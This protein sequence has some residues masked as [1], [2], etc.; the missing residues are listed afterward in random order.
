[1][2]FDAINSFAGVGLK[3]LDWYAYFSLNFTRNLLLICTACG[4]QHPVLMLTD[5]CDKSMALVRTFL[6]KTA[7]SVGLSSSYLDPHRTSWEGTRSRNNSGRPG[8]LTRNLPLPELPSCSWHSRASIQ[9]ALGLSTSWC[10]PEWLNRVCRLSYDGIDFKQII[11][12]GLF[13]SPSSALSNLFIS[14]RQW[15]NHGHRSVSLR[16]NGCAKQ[17]YHAILML[18]CGWEPGRKW[19][20]NQLLLES[21]SASKPEHRSH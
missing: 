17:A 19:F 21:N 6:G 1:M 10:W 13:P 9:I 5:L 4:E 15:G 2:Q 12:C 14:R 18:C 11:V 7:D 3:H 16:W 8:G 20:I